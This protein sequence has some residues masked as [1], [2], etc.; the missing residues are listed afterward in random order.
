MAI[1]TFVAS[2]VLTAAQ[3]NALQ[4]NDYNQTVST[5][6]AS[7][8]LVAAD[9]GTKIVMNSASATT[10]TV[11]TSL[12][13]AG[14]TL[15]ILNISTGVCTVTA[16]TATV[17]T[18]G[19]L[20]LAQN[21]G[22]TLYFTSAGVS[23][24]QANGVASAA[25]GLIAIVPS[26]VTVSGGSATTSTNG[27]VAITSVPL[28]GTVLL[29]GVFSA[30]YTNYRIIINRTADS[31]SSQFSARLSVGGTA[32]TASDYFV[33][34]L[35]V[36]ANVVYG[37]TAT[38]GTSFALEIS[39]RKLAYISLDIMNPFVATHTGIIINSTG[40]TAAGLTGLLA[41][42]FGIN[43]ATTSYDGFQ[44][45]NSSDGASSGTISVYGYNK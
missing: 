42:N 41:N 39:S 5:K 17:S 35:Y 10:I 26:S 28:S 34:Y 29:N 32:S 30:S 36:A 45:V 40:A 18:T 8:T 22:G 19:N 2:T 13:S 31:T 6:T 11:N 14:D 33:N 43:K 1:Q 15:T 3:M 20:A 27:Q 23:V 24:F 9:K 7:Y 12:F 16:G 21:G 4:A 37:E 44:L 25:G 38:A